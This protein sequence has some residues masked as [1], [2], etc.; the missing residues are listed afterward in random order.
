MS[1]VSQTATQA[2][3]LPAPT[4]AAVVPS[5]IITTSTAVVPSATSTNVP[6]Q[7]FQRKRPSLSGP[8]SPSSTS[9]VDNGAKT[10][11][12]GEVTHYNPYDVFG[13]GIGACSATPLKNTN[14]A[15]YA[16]LSNLKMG[17]QSYGNPFCGRT[18]TMHYP[19]LGTFAYKVPILDKCADCVGVLFSLSSAS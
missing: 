11:Y 2:F 3:D 1:A 6:T 7:N 9:V 18:I 19:K 16:A 13:H 8:P 12:I 5:M 17:P 15:A 4:A 14:T 10:T